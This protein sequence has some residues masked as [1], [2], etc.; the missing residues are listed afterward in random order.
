MEANPTKTYVW[1]SL[2]P[3]AKVTNLVGLS[4]NSGRPPYLWQA[5]EV[6]STYSTY[7]CFV[8]AQF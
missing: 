3:P 1:F 8:T 5:F 4:E 2:N 7:N 6:Q